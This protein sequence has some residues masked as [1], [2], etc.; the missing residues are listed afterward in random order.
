MTDRDHWGLRGPILR[1]RLQRTWGCHT[2]LCETGDRSDTTILDFRPDGSL[3]RRSHQ[4]PD[5]SEW[6]STYDYDVTA[7]AWP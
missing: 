4:N 7:G 6:T 5:G 3:A 1:C 2:D